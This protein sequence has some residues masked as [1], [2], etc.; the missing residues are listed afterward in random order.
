MWLPPN[1]PNWYTKSGMNKKILFTLIGIIVV[2]TAA[3]IYVMVTPNDTSAPSPDQASS[4]QSSASSEPAATGEQQLQP[5]TYTAYSEQL[6]AS[7]SGTK[8]LF[9][10][11][12]WC[13]Q[14]RQIEDSI[15]QEGLPDG[16][17]VFKI[18]YDSNQS[19]RQKYG[20]T[21]QT[22]FVKINDAGDKITSYTA[23]Q[24]P[25]FSSVRRELLP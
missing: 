23:Y 25:H 7:T 1:S 4:K 21:I 3:V 11:A 22:T 8:L 9:F 10:H 13:P 6:V 24:E 5:G 2:I 20:V 14:C 18:D 12:P 16:V 15:E 19:L 17:T